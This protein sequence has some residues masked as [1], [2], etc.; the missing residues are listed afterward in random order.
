MTLLTDAP[1]AA[2]A[3]KKTTTAGLDDSAT[4]DLVAVR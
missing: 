2:K 1:P 4:P 3:P